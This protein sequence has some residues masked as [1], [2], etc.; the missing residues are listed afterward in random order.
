MPP[1]LP[2]L[3][4]GVNNSGVDGTLL[5][6]KHICINLFTGKHSQRTVKPLAFFSEIRLKGEKGCK[7]RQR[8][9]ETDTE[10]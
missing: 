5:I 7:V 3:I 10:R 2:I 1:F 6:L 4:K 9:N 8:E